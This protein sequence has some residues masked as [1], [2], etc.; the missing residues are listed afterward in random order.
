[1]APQAMRFKPW[2]LAPK[3]KTKS[4]PWSALPA[5]VLAALTSADQSTMVRGYLINGSWPGATGTQP[6]PSAPEPEQQQEPQTTPKPQ[7]TVEPTPINEA[8]SLSLTIRVVQPTE[9]ETT[10]VELP[11]K[12]S[13]WR[14]FLQVFRGKAA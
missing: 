13:S 7:L 10:P 2:M 6:A 14:R 3:A 4:G 9:G 8:S 11:A 12:P 1:M 5:P